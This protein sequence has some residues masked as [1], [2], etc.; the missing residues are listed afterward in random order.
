MNDVQEENEHR[1]QKSSTLARH[2]VLHDRLLA[3]AEAAIE[4]G[5]LAALRARTLSETVGCSVGAIY[6][7]F[8]DLDALIL[9]VNARTLAAMETAMRA[10]GR[11]RDS[12]DQMRRLASAYLDYA[13]TH[14]NRWRALF[15]HRMSDGRA[16]PAWYAALQAANFSH[17]EEPLGAIQ[18]GLSTRQR[19]LL[20]RT[21]FSAVHGMIDLGLDEK[22]AA[23]PLAVLRTQ[24]KT[25]V[26][27]IAVG[28]GS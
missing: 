25:V 22:V 1:S 9:S 7:V 13:A 3:A 27:A 2:Q 17:I 14:R 16:V 12:A 6:G 21:V 24:V 23:M 28:L 10:A 8:P 26:S 20:A 19:T 11:G 18:P 15:E 4:A 5:G